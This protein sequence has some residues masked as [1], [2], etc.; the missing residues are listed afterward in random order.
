[1]TVASL[2]KTAHCRPSTTPIPVTIP[3][4]GRLAVVDAPCSERADLEKRGARIEQP[5]DPLAGGHLP[6]RAMTLDGGPAAAQ[7][8]ERRPLAQLGDERLHPGP[9]PAELLGAGVDL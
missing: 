2:A 6:A 4:D 5:V 9:A 3:A 8:D 7:R 1:M